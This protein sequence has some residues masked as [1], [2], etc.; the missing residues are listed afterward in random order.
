MGKCLE[1]KV[2]IPLGDFLFAFCSAWVMVPYLDF[3][4]SSSLN[5]HSNIKNWTP[6]SF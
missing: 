4:E 2:L 1:P 6:K 3:E 5:Q